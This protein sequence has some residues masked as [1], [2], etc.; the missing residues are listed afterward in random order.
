MSKDEAEKKRFQFFS[1]KK[2]KI[3]FH[4]VYDN[5]DS[6]DNDDDDCDK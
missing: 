4:S 1:W 2:V 6:V 5:T 3:L